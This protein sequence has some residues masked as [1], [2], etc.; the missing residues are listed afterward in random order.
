M[1]KELI[2][3]SPL[4]NLSLGNTSLNFLLALYK[5]GVKVHYFPIGQP[6]INNYKLDNDFKL[7]L[8]NAGNS[9]LKHYKR[10]MPCWKNWHL[11]GAHSFATDYR[12]LTSYHECDR[13]TQKRRISA[14]V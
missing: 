11:N 1:I 14:K 13:I 2:F 8:Q 4:N 6:D 5:K 9:S 3:E 10:D 12:F 7:W